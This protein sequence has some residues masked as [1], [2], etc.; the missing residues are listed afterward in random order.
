M[1]NTQDDQAILITPDNV[2]KREKLAAWATETNQTRKSLN[3][4]LEFLRK[5]YDSSLP[6]DSRT[7]LET[8]RNIS[9]RNIDNGQYLHIGLQKVLLKFIENNQLCSKD[10]FIDINVDGVPVAKSSSNSLWPILI[11]VVGSEEVM[12]VGCF[13]GSEKPKNVNNYLNEFINE[14]IDLHCNGLNVKGVLY[15]LHVRAIIADAPARAFLLN[16]R[17]YTGYNSCN[18][19]HIKGRYILNRMTFPDSIFISRSDTEFR[20]KQ[21]ENHHLNLYATAIET[22]P[23][24]CVKNV[25]IDYMHACLEGVLKQ[26]LIQWILIRKK[27]YSMSKNNIRIFSNNI[28]IISQQLP[29]EFERTPRT[30]QYLKRYKATEFRQLLLYTLPILL[31]NIIDHSIYKHFLKLH[32]AIRILCSKQFHITLNEQASEF[33]V[34]FI[35]EFDG[36]YDDHQYSFNVHSLLHLCADVLYF[37]SPLDGFS[38]FKFENFLQY[39]KKLVRSGKDPLKQI[40]NRY[41]EKYLFLNTSTWHKAQQNKYCKNSN[42]NYKYIHLNHFKFSCTEPNNYCYNTDEKYFIKIIT[43]KDA[44][45]GSYEIY[46]RKIQQTFPIYTEP[47]DSRELGLHECMVISLNDI[48]VFRLNANIVKAVKIELN[49]KYYLFSLLH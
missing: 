27:T 23:I 44:I 5:E 48:E 26:L 31:Q 15:N 24:D 11:S 30:L 6:K 8:P 12:C 17:S 43:I 47:I 16:I 49:D 19:C 41:S 14:F 37:Q 9:I 2:S 45:D 36:F 1:S 13:Y 18:K 38:S 22:L 10:V 42:G 32:C 33:L 35:E 28:I 25:A 40:N 3:L 21:Y 34:S 46:G 7:L 20:S 39:L 29:Y 4:L